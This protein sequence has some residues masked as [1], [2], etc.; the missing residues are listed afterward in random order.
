MFKSEKIDINGYRDIV[1]I[2]WDI[3][4]IYK[5]NVG[6]DPGLLRSIIIVSINT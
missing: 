1:I 4:F 2:V 3:S 6:F 5:D